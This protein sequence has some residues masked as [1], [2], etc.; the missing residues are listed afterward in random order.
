MPRAAYRVSPSDL[1]EHLADLVPE[2]MVPSAI[3]L[4]EELPLTSSGKVDRKRLPAPD[5]RAELSGYVAARTPTEEAL[6]RIWC[7]VLRIDRVGVTDNFFTLGGDSIQSIKVVARAARAGLRLTVKQI[8]AHPTIEALA[9]VACELPGRPA[10][11]SATEGE[12]PLTPVQRHFFET[13]QQFNHF[14]QAVLLACRRPLL[15]SRVKSAIA[16]LL[17][18]HDAL[19]MRFERT[20]RGWRQRYGAVSDEAGN[21]D[22]IPFEHID[23]SSVTGS[24]RE[25]ALTR[26]AERLQKGLDL[27]A[28]PLLRAALIELG[29]RGQRLLLVIHHLVVDV[30]SWRILL[31]DLQALCETD[32]PETAV[33]PPKTSSFGHWAQRLV[34][35]SSSDALRTQLTYWLAR[36]WDRAGRVPLD[37]R[38]GV[39]SLS[40]QRDL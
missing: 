33:L 19:R 13:H 25:S 38:D 17:V 35:Y 6:S 9:N 11:Q 27:S 14:N 32:A 1:R 21:P 28:G 24:E 29:D 12:V 30:V 7:E 20:D 37:H 40:S 10:Q 34:E 15:A 22:R 8:F 18:H 36:P 4:L 5:M 39:N 2:Y 26:E 31:E 23:L 16:R 3:V